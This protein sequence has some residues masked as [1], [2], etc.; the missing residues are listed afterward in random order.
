[1]LVGGLIE[2]MFGQSMKKLRRFFP[3]VVTG[4][5]VLAMGISLLPTGINY[6]AG[7]VGASDFGSISN[8][9]LGTVVLL[10]VL[11]F[12]QYTKG[13]TSLA[14]ILIGLIVGY[15]VA[16]PMGKIDFSQLSQM[17]MISVPMPFTFGFEFHLDTNICSSLCIYSFSC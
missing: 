7:G 2:V 11:I 17:S 13:I 9:I 15:I 1:M 16:I 6:F 12:N 14:S 8:L 10:T 5:V 3:S 4:T